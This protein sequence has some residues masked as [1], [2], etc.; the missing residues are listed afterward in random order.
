MAR[1]LL[2]IPT[3]TYRTSAFMQAA[4]DL[5]LEVV[6][7]SDKRQSLA[8]LTPG[9]TLVLDFLN[10][11][12]AVKSIVEE[13]ANRP[14]QAIVGVDDDTVVLAAMAN[15]ALGLQHNSVAS[16]EVTRNK[17]L[18]RQALEKAPILSPAL[19]LFDV[20][21]DINACAQKVSYPC[22]LKP[23]FLSGSRGVIRANDPEEF[24]QAFEEIAQFLSDPAIQEK[25]GASARQVLVEDYISGV[26]VA[27]EGVLV[28]G[29]LKVLALFDKPDLLEGPFFV[30]T[31]YVTPS[32]L[33]LS[34]Q[35]DIFQTTQK[36]AQA[37][38]LREGPIHAELRYNA[39]GAWVVEIAAR[40]IGGLCSRMLVFG[41][42]LSLEEL[43]LHH[44]MGRNISAAKR[45]DHAA[46]VMM[47]PVE[48]HGIL[49]TVEGTEVAMEVPGIEDV[50]ISIPLGQGVQ[51]LPRG[52]QYLGFIFASGSSPDGV[53]AALR[54][55][56]H[57]LDIQITAL[58]K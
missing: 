51:P 28:Q 41:G 35:E 55:A 46:G 2:L 11:E 9:T 8:H 24:K 29:Q 45:K 15:Q 16:V 38:G 21:D 3:T 52:D 56:H 14:F 49:E 40:S 26:E 5:Q 10:P 34:E 31:L 23:T 43:I 19:N 4:E 39:E 1:V 30:E 50:V 53:E 48:K 6:V 36:A 44:A 20:L 33:P 22:V 32:R 18:M 57:L 25:G 42:G 27:L 12:T 13:A 37:L 58:E 7:G 17:Y 54:N 47:I